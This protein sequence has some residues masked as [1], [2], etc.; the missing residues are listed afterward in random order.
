MGEAAD[1]VPS[2]T[3]PPGNGS[4]IS[5]LLDTRSTE[6]FI[7]PTALPLVGSETVPPCRASGRSDNHREDLI[8]SLAVVD[9]ICNLFVERG[10]GIK[11]RFAKV[12]D[13]A[14]VGVSEFLC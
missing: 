9:L 13:P 8:H 1:L 12:F 10:A 3:G 4:A 14:A 11:L 5:R 6:T 2:K 7:R